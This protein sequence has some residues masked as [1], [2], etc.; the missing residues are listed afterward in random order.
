MSLRLPEAHERRHSQTDEPE[1]Y[2][3]CR[4]LGIDLLIAPAVLV[5]RSETEILGREAVEILGGMDGSPVVIDMCCGSGNLALAIAHH[6]PT[7]RIWAADLT[8]SCVA[9]ARE[10]VQRHTLATRI[11]IRQGDLF[12][13]VADDDL[14][15]KADLIV[16]NPPYIS[17]SRLDNESAHLLE[18]E[19]RA[20]FDAG[21][22]GISILQRL[23]K[24][25]VGYLKPDGWLM[26]EFGAGQQKLVASLLARTKSYGK[27]TFAMADG[28]PRVAIARHQPTGSIREHL[29]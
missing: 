24:E 15:G 2:S 17:S 1:R 21:P 12:A 23:V 20:A 8:D 28:E 25:A 22:Y 19:P 18:N 10:N 14:A 16:C 26:F 11:A 4:F 3:S 13:A 5:P 7:A 27:L 9:L 6:C 29:R